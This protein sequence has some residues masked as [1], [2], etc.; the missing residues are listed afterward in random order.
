MRVYRIAYKVLVG[1][2]GVVRYVWWWAADVACG[3]ALC[4]RDPRDTAR[5]IYIM[6]MN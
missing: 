4:G 3:R 2:A 1:A 5:I 6:L